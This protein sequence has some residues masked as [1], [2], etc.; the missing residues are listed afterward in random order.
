M[1][2]ASLATLYLPLVSEWVS[3]WLTDCHFRIWTQIVTFVTWD[4]LDI[5]SMIIVIARQKESSILWGQGR[6]FALRVFKRRILD[7]PVNLWK[8]NGSQLEPCKQ[9]QTRPINGDEVLM[10][11]VLMLMLILMIMMLGYQAKSEKKVPELLIVLTLVIMSLVRMTLMIMATVH[12]HLWEEE[13]EEENR[14]AAESRN[15]RGGR[16]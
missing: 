2:L 4:P 13:E 11:I 12:E 14:M 16:W 1:V 9:T 7:L 8:E 5:W 10:L 3:D 15:G 6:S